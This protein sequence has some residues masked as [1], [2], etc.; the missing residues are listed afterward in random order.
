MDSYMATLSLTT[1]ELSPVQAGDTAFHQS[2]LNIDLNANTTDAA[3]CFTTHEVNQF[4]NTPTVVYHNGTPTSTPILVREG[5]K[6]P[7]TGMNLQ[8]VCVCVCLCLYF[9]EMKV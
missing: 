4:E 3:L 9:M 7:D 1:Q 5:Q 2:V 6:Y 8:L